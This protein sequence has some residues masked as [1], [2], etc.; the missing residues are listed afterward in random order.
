MPLVA[1]RRRGC[2][3]AAAI[4]PPWAACVRPHIHVP[5]LGVEEHVA[6]RGFF[7]VYLSI[8]LSVAN[9]SRLGFVFVTR[10]G[11]VYVGVQKSCT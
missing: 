7:I 1:W 9:R 4:R 3:F 10:G 6:M 2:R 5:F 11:L 8:L